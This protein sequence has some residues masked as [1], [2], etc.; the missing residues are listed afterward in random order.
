MTFTRGAMIANLIFNFEIM[1]ESQKTA[2]T[3]EFP[4]ARQPALCSGDGRAGS[5]SPSPKPGAHLVFTDG[6]CLPTLIA[7]L[8]RNIVRAKR[9]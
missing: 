6:W 1:I 2:K 3:V 9:S 5:D 4:C 8:T 7:P